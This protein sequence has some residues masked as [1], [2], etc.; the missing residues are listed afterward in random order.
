MKYDVRVENRHSMDVVITG[1]DEDDVGST[2]CQWC[3][4]YTV[5]KV[6]QH[7]ENEDER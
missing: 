2:V 3:G 6:T 4:P 1:V 5:V 7:K